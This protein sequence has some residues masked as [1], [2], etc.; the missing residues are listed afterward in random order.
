MEM[1]RDALAGAAE[2]V[3]AIERIGGG[4]P[5]PGLVATVGELLV[6]PGAS[7]VIPGAVRFTLDLRSSH[8]EDRRAALKAIKRELADIATRR[9]LTIG[10]KLGSD[11]SAISCDPSLIAAIDAACGE[12]QDCPIHLTSGAGH[13]GIALSRLCPVGMIF[14]RCAGGVSHN[15]AESITEADAGF[16]FATLLRTILN[17]SESA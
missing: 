1:R 16:G 11:S 2:A 3:L 17:L 12:E 4:D 8:D 14:V 9:D 15:P 13:D 10:F 5:D 7:N 6:E